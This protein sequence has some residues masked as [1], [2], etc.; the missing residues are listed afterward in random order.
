[1]LDPSDLYEL[2]ADVPELDRPLDHPV[3]L[4]NLNGFVDAGA[5]GK[6]LR[7][8]LLGSVVHAGLASFD[9]DRLIDY[10]ARRPTMTFEDSG[11]RDYA[12]PELTIDVLADRAGTPFLMLHGP[13]P[14]HEWERFCAAVI[15]L[16]ERLEVSLTVGFYGIP[17]AV[18]HTR[19]TT[20]IERTSRPE[21]VR[22]PSPWLGRVQVPGS[23]E[24]LLELRLSDAGHDV[25]GFA[26]HVPH[27]LAQLE[28][29]PAAL[30]ALELVTEATGLDID[31][32]ELTDAAQ[33]G[34]ADVDRQVAESDE[35]GSVVRALEEQYDAFTRGAAQGGLLA[36]QPSMPTADELGAEFE[37]FLAER[38]R[39]QGQG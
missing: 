8:H 4:V 32:G 36:E 31:P 34:R 5:A 33:R 13:E 1:M 6:L 15:E 14:D 11:W 17:M 35:V 27:Y 25:C 24:G 2:G 7:D 37:R 20:A 18:P 3:L 12:A 9:V 21:L 30:T 22:H 19:P 16:V 38:D 23:I 10:R 29:A 28:Y 26:V 39:G